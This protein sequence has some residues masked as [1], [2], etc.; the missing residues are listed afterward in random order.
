LLGRIRRQPLTFSSLVLMIFLF[1]LPTFG[2]FSPLLLPSIYPKLAP[3][4]WHNITPHGNIVLYSYDASVDEPGL[5]L[6]CGSLFTITWNDPSTWRFG[7]KHDWLSQNGGITWKRL[8][9]PFDLGDDCTVALPLGHLGT[10]VEV[11]S[12][13]DN[14]PLAPATVWVSHDYGRSWTQQPQA[15]SALDSG[16]WIY[17]HGVLYGDQTDGATGAARFSRSTDD[18]IAWTALS[19]IPDRLVGSD[20]LFEGYVPD[21][22]QD[23]AWYGELTHAGQ[24]STLIS[25]QDD[26]ATWVKFG[27]IPAPQA[28]VLATSPLAPDHICAASATD[29]PARVRILTGSDGGTTWHIGVL[30]SSIPTIGF[31]ETART[32]ATLMQRRATL[33]SC[34]SR[35][36]AMARVSFQSQTAETSWETHSSCPRANMPGSSS[37]PFRRVVKANGP[38][39]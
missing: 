37:S 32:T 23:Y 35:R 22:R 12:H 25:S 20:R 15:G 36:E 28:L 7:Q 24:P 39:P 1:L 2:A 27:Q 21:F 38:M 34:N 26:G 4:G 11:I 29:A 13:G 6:A 33:R 14:A 19:E 3:E 9:T 30:P 18:G 31:A 5:V 10:L 17:R 8:D 16:S